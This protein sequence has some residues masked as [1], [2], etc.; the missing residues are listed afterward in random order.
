[1]VIDTNILIA[2]LKGE[3]RV[4]I[5]LSAWK[6]EGRALFI[7]PISI[8]EVLAIAPLSNA[9]IITIKEFLKNFISIP[10]D[11][12]IAEIAGY[13]R[14]T[15]R[16]ALPDAII[17]ATAFLRNAPLATRDQQFKK[18]KEIIMLNI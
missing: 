3:Q 11:D 8:A 1:M 6:E 10:I 5:Q 12:S 9:E 16:I 7:S 14:G 17:A 15:Y 4:V 2:Y 18:I 13:F